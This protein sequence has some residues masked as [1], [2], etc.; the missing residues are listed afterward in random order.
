[1][2]SC[3]LQSGVV[4]YKTGGPANRT[5][6]LRNSVFERSL[7][8]FQDQFNLRGNNEETVTANNNLF[9][10][11][12]L[13]LTPPAGGSQG[14]NWKF[15][16]NIFDNASFHGPGAQHGTGPAVNNNNAYVNMTARLYPTAPTSTDPNL[17]SV[18]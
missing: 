15:I 13:W 14:A 5:L 11:C 18:S 7:L 10:N 9:W 3:L 2:P 17:A 6:N 4:A 1:M 8:A 12:E 16:D